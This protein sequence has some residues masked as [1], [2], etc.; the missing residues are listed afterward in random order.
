MVKVYGPMMSIDASGTLASTA[1]F[2]K[3]KGR[4]YVRKR[5]IPKNPKSGSQTGIRSM[6]RWLSKIWDGLS[7]ADKATWEARAA[8]SIISPFNAF[9]AYNISRWRDFNTPTK[10][11]P[12][13]EVKTEP[14]GPTGVATP[15]GRSMIL[16][17]TDGVTPPDWGYAIFRS[18]TAT[19]TLAWSNC[20]R[21]VDWDSGGV[22]TYIDSPLEPDTYYYNA[23]GFQD[24]GK[25]G[26][27]GTEFS[28]EIT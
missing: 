28:G 6:F 1:T 23:V 5:V 14:T 18:L 8:A 10:Q 13:T 21:V 3:W 20:I 24:D 26:A 4:N 7:A 19:F 11:D 25:E 17:I 9:M 15:D 12:A 16:A 27:D 22:T 2:S